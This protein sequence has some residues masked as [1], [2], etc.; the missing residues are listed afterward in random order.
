MMLHHVF[1]LSFLKKLMSKTQHSFEQEVSAQNESKI[2]HYD[3][4]T[5]ALLLDNLPPISP[6][7]KKNKSNTSSNS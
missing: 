5:Y 4:H 1:K 3:E 7:T 6:P 2:E